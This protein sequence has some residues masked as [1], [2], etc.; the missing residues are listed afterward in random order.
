MTCDH[1][2]FRCTNGVFFCLI[3][4]QEIPNPYKVAKPAKKKK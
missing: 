4:G 3:C 1:S 2:L